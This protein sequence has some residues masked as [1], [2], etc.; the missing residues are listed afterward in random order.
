[1]I[2]CENLRDTIQEMKDT[3][4]PWDEWKRETLLEDSRL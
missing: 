4:L 2:P 1:M 3:L